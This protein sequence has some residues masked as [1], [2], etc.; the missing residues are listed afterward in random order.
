[1]LTKFYCIMYEL[2]ITGYFNL[3]SMSILRRICLWGSPGGP[4]VKSLPS[5]AGGVGLIHGPKIPHA[6]LCSQEIN[7]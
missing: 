1:M 7:K 5:S 4:V 3:N 6:M 2:C